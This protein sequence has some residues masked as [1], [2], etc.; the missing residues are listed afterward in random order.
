MSSSAVVPVVAA[1]TVGVLVAAAMGPWKPGIGLWLLGASGL[2]VLYV[3]LLFRLRW[4]LLLFLVLLPSQY[5]DLTAGR[6]GFVLSPTRVILP[7]LA[8][9]WLIYRL[10]RHNSAEAIPLNHRLLA[11]IG[12]LLFL[13]CLSAP[14]GQDWRTS[15]AGL[16]RLAEGVV[17]F[18]ILIDV[19]R[20]E[21]HL[22]QA[23]LAICIALAIVAFTAV[24]DFLLS[25][26]DFVTKAQL[27]LEY[28]RAT[29]II[30]Q[31]NQAAD[32]VAILFPLLLY[33]L[34]VSR[35][36]LCAWAL[37]AI[38]L[39]AVLGVLLT[40]SRGGSL[41]LLVGI[42]VSYM[43][44]IS[45]K[46]ILL[47]LV[48]AVVLATTPLSD[49]WLENVG[50][51][52]ES[53]TRRLGLMYAGLRSALEF[54]LFGTGFRTFNYLH[55]Y[56][57]FD[58]PADLFE[59]HDPELNK[60]AHSLYVCLLAE[61]GFLSLV[62]LGM[63]WWRLLRSLQELGRHTSSAGMKR[64]WWLVQFL[65]GCSAALIVSRAFTTDLYVLAFWAL[66]GISISA[67]SIIA[68]QL[69]LPI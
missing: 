50:A 2:L 46:V 10:R 61:T 31:P 21:K 4:G 54:P 48:L 23:I 40:L 55:R 24:Y 65:T 52:P 36:R 68:R 60:S 51:R 38:A 11:P 42:A 41:A 17:V 63:F 58:W 47:L 45:T 30:G 57:S 44:K 67:T 33:A 64:Q 27:S 9:A 59:K 18:V 22:H 14:L 37:S 25:P 29:S 49:I 16:F 39:T 7:G 56:V 3:A 8:I 1:I 13:M 66:L 5:V 26:Q 28:V 43:R 20:T 15:V 62:F 12:A 69:Q 32:S 34:T 35:S 53:V 19:V 6:L